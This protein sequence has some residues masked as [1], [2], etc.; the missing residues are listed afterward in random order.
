MQISPH[1]EALQ[2]Q[3]LSAAAA[4]GPQAEELAGRL[5]VALDAAARLAILDALSD[6]AGEITRELAPGSVDVRLRGRDVE[7]AVSSPARLESHS[8]AETSPTTQPVPTDAAD[9]GDD[10]S[11]SRTTLRVP[12]AL[13]ARAEAAAANEGVSL[14]TWLVRAISAALEPRRDPREPNSS[15]YSGWVR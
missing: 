5:A 15:R 8:A 12:D 10:A 2:R 13:K 9:D 7:F 11:T 4:G 3:L 6:A 14:N 1:V